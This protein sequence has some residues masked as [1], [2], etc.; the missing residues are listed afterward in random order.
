MTAR[1]DTGRKCGPCHGGLSGS[2]GRDAR[3]P[4]LF[5][6]S[7]QIGE[8]VFFEQ[9]LDDTGV[10]TIQTDDDDLLDG[11]ILNLGIIDQ[12]ARPERADS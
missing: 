7:C 10:Q 2:R 6:E 9:P 8:L 3:K 12:W 4:P 11:S 5:F 1:V